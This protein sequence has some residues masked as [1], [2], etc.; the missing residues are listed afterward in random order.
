M[1]TAWHTASPSIYLHVNAHALMLTDI[2]I[3][4]NCN[5][6]DNTLPYEMKAEGKQFEKCLFLSATYCHGFVFNIND[7]LHNP[8]NIFE[9][10]WHLPLLIKIITI[11]S[12]YQFFIIVYL[13]CM[14]ACSVPSV[15]F[16]SLQPS[17]LYSLPG[18]SV[19]GILQAR[20]LE[21]ILYVFKDSLRFF[22]LEISTIFACSK[23]RV[24]YFMNFI[25]AKVSI[26]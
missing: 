23:V 14:H 16:D 9:V 6:C 13:M 15:P 26:A 18:F 11:W 21:W 24:V 20:I 19:N 10:L 4:L 25:S 22:C 8:Q 3:P 2:H 17:G 7:V 1:S 5:I 12:V